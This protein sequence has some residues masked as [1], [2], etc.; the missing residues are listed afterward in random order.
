MTWIWPFHW[1]H[2]WGIASISKQVW[3]HSGAWIGSSRR[4]WHGGCRSI[5]HTPNNT[6]WYTHPNSRGCSNGTTIQGITS[7]ARFEIESYRQSESLWHCQHQGNRKYRC[8]SDTGG[9]HPTATIGW[10]YLGSRR[11]SRASGGACGNQRKGWRRSFCMKLLAL[12]GLWSR[13]VAVSLKL[14]AL[15]KLHEKS[16]RLHVWLVCLPTFVH[17]LVDFYGE[18]D[19]MGMATRFFL[20]KWRICSWKWVAHRAPGS[21]QL[22][23]KKMSSALS[24]CISTRWALDP[25]INRVT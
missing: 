4:R 15:W 14:T 1:L 9:A 16:Q 23:P 3:E 8:N 20:T 5:H 21:L 17:I 25:V 13:V 22:A 10:Q 6:R 7:Q 12:L 24:R 18:W 2:L 19:P 11:A